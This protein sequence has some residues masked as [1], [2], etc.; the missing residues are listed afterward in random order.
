M[1]VFIFIIIV[2]VATFALFK[3]SD[4]AKRNQTV[5]WGTLNSVQMTTLFNKIT[6][7]D[8]KFSMVY[9]EK[10]PESFESDLIEALAAGAGPDAVLLPQ[11]LIYRNANKLI[12]IPYT[13]LS[14]RSFKDTYLSEGELF[15]STNGITALPLTVDP[16]VLYW[17]RT[18]LTNAG[19]AA[20]PATWTELLAMTPKL[21]VKNNTIITQAAISFGGYENTTNA[22][23]ILSA[24]LLQ[25]GTPITNYGDTGILQ[26]VLGDRFNY[27]LTPAEEAL[28]FYT[29]FADPQKPNYSWNP[30][31]PTAR[32]YFVSGDLAFYVG[33]AS[34]LKDIRDRNPNLDFDVS[35]LP[36]TD[37][38]LARQT[39]GRVLGLAFTKNLHDMASTFANALDLTSTD[40]LKLLSELTSLPPGRRDLLSVRPADPYL[41][42]FYDSA[43]MSRGWID[44]D[45]E[46]SDT[47]FK[48]MVK[49]VTSG[50]AR[51][52]E[53]V[54]QATAELGSLIK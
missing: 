19:I 36:Q 6:Q 1:A 24:L 32:S 38:T 26:S 20:P 25:A 8:D 54:N 43:L 48:N 23:E 33:F 41:S 30:S 52:S 53:A 46:G 17:N 28:R 21:V 11:D 51:I 2:A 10:R 9:V 37:K 45:R 42:V 40:S 35:I 4:T 12:P 7:A 3:G 44:P 49:S 14:E 29:G 13:S 39:F 27:A 15:L 50:R 34:E 5:L 22:K 16:L 47:V 18:L 31:L